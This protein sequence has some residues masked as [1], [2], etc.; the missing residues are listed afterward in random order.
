MFRGIFNKREV[1]PKGKRQ[2]RGPSVVPA[3]PMQ[4]ASRTDMVIDDSLLAISRELS[5]LKQTEVPQGAKERGWASLQRELERRPVRPAVTA[6]VKS[7]AGGSRR[8]PSH[9]WRWALGGAAGAIAIVATLI[10]TLGGGAPQVA[11]NDSTTLTSVVT[12]DSTLPGTT[13]SVPPVSTDASSST[14]TTQPSTTPT[15]GTSTTDAN[16]ST[17]VTNTTGRT[18]PTAGSSTTQPTT[19]TT[20]GE[21]QNAAHQR[22]TSAKNLVASLG[23]IAVTGNTSGSS[24]L[25]APSAQAALA[26]MIMSLQEPHGW[27]INPDVQTLSSN[28]LRL[29]LNINDRIVNGKGEQVETVKHFFVQVRVDAGS[30]VIIAINAGS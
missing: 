14:D 18:T 25:V 28:V 17:T 13:E 23:N 12:T 16:T 24:S 11:I 5:A 3:S 27:T 2:E 7:P 6:G 21:Q 22:E 4:D 26:Q 19:P 29:T 20:T 8:G 1:D 10:A 30:A 9:T 15:A